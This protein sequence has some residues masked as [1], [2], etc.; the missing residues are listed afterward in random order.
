MSV[1]STVL[2]SL[3]SMIGWI[4]LSALLLNGAL[5]M[6]QP[7]MVFHPTRVLVETPADWGL[8]YEDVE[9]IA[10]DGTLLHG[11]F[12]DHPAATHTLLFFHGNA[13]NIS[14]R[15]D[16]IAILQRLG[17]SVLIIDYRGY[18]R[19]GGRPSEAGLYLDAQA[20]W[21]HLI[22]DRRIAPERIILFG[23]SLGAGVA[24][25][26]AAR[27]RPAGVILEAGFSSARDMARHLYPVLHHVLL[28]RY[29]FDAAARLGQVRAPVLILHSQGDEI[30]PDALGRR[31][32]A[33]AS[34][35]KRFVTL[36]GGHNDGFL[37]SQPD[38]AR[39]LAEFIATLDPSPVAGAR[40]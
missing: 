14:H 23:R 32:F 4:L 10:R 13:G 15:G 11:W 1:S 2:A 34:E 25:D 21:D 19:S 5:W 29:D 6:L 20:A 24:A 38:Y 26:L 30:V 16:S 3:L 37:A 12:I 40:D 36:R 7:A 27:V 39:T 22:D 33:A 8:D 35:P 9:L 17:L 31:L 28:M 18:G